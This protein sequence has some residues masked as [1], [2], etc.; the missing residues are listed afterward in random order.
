MHTPIS[1]SVEEKHMQQISLVLS[2]CSIVCLV[3]TIIERHHRSGNRHDCS[4]RYDRTGW[5]FCKW[6]STAL[7]L[8]MDRRPLMG[9]GPVRGSPWG[10]R[11]WHWRVLPLRFCQS[12]EI[13]TSTLS[14]ET[15]RSSDVLKPSPIRRAVSTL[16]YA[17]PLHPAPEDIYP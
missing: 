1:R 16:V 17:T 9:R 4:R 3:E 14:H 10:P 6:P 7:S 5:P 13:G 15:K 8:V 2:A 12:K 11:A